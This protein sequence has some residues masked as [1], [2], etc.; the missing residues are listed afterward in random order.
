MLLL[1]PFVF[2]AILSDSRS[3]D[4]IRWNFNE[5]FRGNHSHG[6]SQETGLKNAF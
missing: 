3:L 1:M 5:G 6:S 4:G 2:N